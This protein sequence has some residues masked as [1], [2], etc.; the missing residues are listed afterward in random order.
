[1][2]QPDDRLAIDAAPPAA[3]PAPIAVVPR[4]SA[5]SP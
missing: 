1:M 4:L 5:P 3:R 2:T